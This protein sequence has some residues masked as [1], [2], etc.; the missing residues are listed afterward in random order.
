MG[1][2]RVDVAKTKCR[3]TKGVETCRYL[4]IRADG[5]ECLRNTSERFL[6][7]RRVARGTAHAKGLG[8]KQEYFGILI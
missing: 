6:I 4:A 2:I 7:D 3:W 8:C 5:F 1:I